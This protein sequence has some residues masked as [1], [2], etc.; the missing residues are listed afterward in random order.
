M[1]TIDFLLSGKAIFTV[2]N[3]SKERYTF[4]VYKN[5]RFNLFF[6]SMLT[7]NNNNTDY[8]YI[9]RFSTEY[10]QLVI[11]SKSKITHNSKPFEVFN[12]A[13]KHIIT[14]KPV[15]DGYFIEHNGH[16]GRCG[17]VLTTPESI[18]TGLGPVCRGK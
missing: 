1:I 5:K 4:K 8:T 14:Q 12:W 2:A 6:V 13:V 11:T 7:G 18:K 16:C 15:P 9:G 10:K 17:R 3:P